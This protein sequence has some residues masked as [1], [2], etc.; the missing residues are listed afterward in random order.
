MRRP[1]LAGARRLGAGAA[2][3]LLFVLL[4][5]AAP[6]GAK[7]PRSF[8]GVQSWA[9][10]PT[11]AEFHRMGQGHLGTYR[12]DLFWGGVEPTRG[13]R[14]WTEYD[15]I[16]ANAAKEGI[17]VLPVLISSPRFAAS[18]P[19]FPPRTK[20][21]KQA[22][23]AFVT[24]AVKRYGPKG[25]LW[26]ANPSLPYRPIHEWQIWN[27]P[28]FPV[29]W[30]NRPNARQ[31]A[32]FVKLTAKAIRAVDPAATI[33]LAGLPES[34]HGIP[35]V[36]Y[37]TSFYRVKGIKKYFDVVAVHPYARG[38]AGVIGAVQ[39][40]R[41]IMNRFGD[42]SKQIWV[43]EVGWASSGPKKRNPFVTTKR[44]QAARLK[45]TFALVVRK[46]ATYNIGMIIWFAWRD[47]PLMRGEKNWWAPHTGLFDLRGRPKPAW[48]AYVRF[49]R[50]NVGG[51]SVGPAPPSTPGSTTIG[52]SGG[53]AP[54][55]SSNPPPPS[56]PSPPPPPSPTPCVPVPPL[57]TCP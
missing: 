39:R 19:Q 29:Y 25:T 53:G 24:D 44:G 16:V 41:S 18:R 37:L 7:V 55:P 13:Q 11:P 38:P 47:R 17:D 30:F 33:A 1:P 28:N 6:A 54:P 56:N 23:A 45:S 20:A 9:F 27:E 26:A 43:T 8:F 32:A 31:Y 50:G 51:G 12:V 10:N 42:S 15:Q 2:V 48:R 3:L 36:K 52:P 22:F 21:G 14:I 34:K 5:T 46:K 4:A 57:L 35:I 40:V 49:T